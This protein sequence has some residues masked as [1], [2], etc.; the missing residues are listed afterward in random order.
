V[1]FGAVRVHEI[2]SRASHERFESKSR[3]QTRREH[4]GCLADAGTITG[5]APDQARQRQDDS[6]N[7]RRL[8]PGLK[9]SVPEQC[10]DRVD[11]AFAQRGQQ[12]QKA[13]L[14]AAEIDARI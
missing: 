11:A 9:R 12:E 5:A 10:H 3:W 6:L 4:A 14:G 1:G 7:A 8:Q 13:L 2:R